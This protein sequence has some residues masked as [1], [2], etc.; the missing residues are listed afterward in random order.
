MNETNIIPV[1]TP[2]L[3]I[4]NIANYLNISSQAVHKQIK[5]KDITCPKIGKYSYITHAVSKQLLNIKFKKKKLI[6]HIVKGG[7]GKTTS[8][9]NIASCINAYGAKVLL[10]DIDPQGNLTDAMGIDAEEKP[11]LIDFINDDIPIKNGL[12]RIADGIDLICSR[13]ENVVLDS[14]MVY[15]QLPLTRI[16]DDLFSEIEKDYDFIFIDCPPTLGHT[17][18][19]AYLY[20]DLVIAPLAPNKFSSKGLKILQKEVKGIK[21]K[22]KKEINWKCFLNKFSQTTIL[23]EKTIAELFTNPSLEDKTLKSAVRFAQE[24]ENLV[25]EN[26]SLFSS[27][28]KSFARDD[29]ELLTRELFELNPHS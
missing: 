27:I 16:F 8:I 21:K 4:Q 29:F 26:K 15:E 17:V 13:I 28:R 23:S 3:S 1:N 6:F 9:Y 24:I 14:I 11:V 2:V 20:G 25:D 5:A 18:T 10:I 12:V 22:F 7:T 19:A